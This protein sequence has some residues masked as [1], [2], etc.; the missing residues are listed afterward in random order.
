MSALSVIQTSIRK[1]FSNELFGVDLFCRGLYLFLFL[2]ILFTWPLINSVMSYAP[3]KLNSWGNFLFAPLYMLKG[4]VHCFVGVSLIITGSAVF[5][6]LNYISAILTFWV[7]ISL[8][9]L[10]VPLLNG[11]DLVLNLFLL[12]AIL[13]PGFPLVKRKVTQDFQ[14]Y[15]SAV[16][17]LFVKVEI[18]LIYFLSGFDKLMTESWRSGAAVYSV[19][20]LDFFS[21]P[22]FA[23]ELSEINAVGM[24]WLI[25][26]F[27][28][29]FPVL[30]WF[31]KFRTPMLLMGVLFHVCIII[32]LGLLDFGILM[33]LSYF[34]FLPVK[35]AGRDDFKQVLGIQ[36]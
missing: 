10:L 9:R 7:S 15:V 4:G 29:A 23:I 6:R 31:P 28:L 2:K 19:S 14:K 12:I 26:S 20:K 35:Q 1:K 16:G 27:E 36:L 3:V 21:N 32:F 17:I 22:A 5:V 30:I 11:S 18:A 34:I 25:I 33:M 13:I 24:A 8:S